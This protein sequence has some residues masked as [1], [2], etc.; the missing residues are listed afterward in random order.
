MEQGTP[1]NPTEQVLE[2][3]AAI[4]SGQASR[5]AEVAPLVTR[6]HQEMNRYFDGFLKAIEAEGPAYEQ[7]L[8]EPISLVEDYFTSYDGALKQIADSIPSR[9]LKNLAEGAKELRRA[10]LGLRLAMEHYDESFLAMGPNRF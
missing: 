9:N 4:Q 8:E 3:C 1:Q 5:W 10:A 6:R 2:L 7:K